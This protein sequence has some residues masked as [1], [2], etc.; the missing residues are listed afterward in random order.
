[1]TGSSALF[2]ADYYLCM[3]PRWLQEGSRSFSERRRRELDGFSKLHLR[4]RGPSASARSCSGGCCPRR[5]PPS[6]AEDSLPA[7][8]ERYG[9]DAEQHERIR[10]DLRGER[11][12][13]AKNRLPAD[14][15][16]EDVRPSDVV[17][18]Q[19]LGVEA[20][21]AGRAALARARCS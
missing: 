4:G 15:P 12:G 8:L 14:T 5:R 3:L 18:T 11:I 9:F 10:A 13:L 19:A 20:E 2:S 6:D 16:I 1:M 17:Q 7:L 21:R